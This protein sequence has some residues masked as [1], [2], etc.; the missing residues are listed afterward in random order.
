[1]TRCTYLCGCLL[2]GLV[3]LTCSF[4]ARA[5]ERP[6][7]ED[8]AG[9]RDHPILARYPGG[10]ITAL[11]AREREDDVE[12]AIGADRTVK[13]SGRYYLSRYRYPP[14]STCDSI[15]RSYRASLERAGLRLYA[16]TA[17]PEGAARSMAVSRI[18]GWVTATGLGSSG[19]V[20]V[21]AA[22][23]GSTAGPSG[24]VLV[25]ETGE[26]QALGPPSASL[27]PPT[28][29]RIQGTRRNWDTGPERAAP[30]AGEPAEIVL[31]CPERVAVRLG[32]VAPVDFKEAASD[33]PGT[34]TSRWTARLAPASLTRELTLAGSEIAAGDVTCRYQSPREGAEFAMAVSRPIPWGRSCAPRSGAGSGQ[35]SCVRR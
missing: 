18:D 21:S 1:M 4:A 17:L 27:P 35:F 28:R 32:P 9:T 33:Y 8:L 22:C 15:L 30:V 3:G 12:L 11:S 24:P 34:G 20:Y 16:G 2:A 29:G 31:R 10:A 26:R 6:G 5:G 7:V 14:D 23:S 13:A 19:V 25:I